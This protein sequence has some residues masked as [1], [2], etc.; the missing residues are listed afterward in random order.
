[1]VLISLP[2]LLSLPSRSISRMCRRGRWRDRRLR[3]II[4]DRVIIYFVEGIGYVYI[5]CVW[6]LGELLVQSRRGW[7]SGTR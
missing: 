6:D 5:E 7:Y 3:M 4:I 2:S 1:M